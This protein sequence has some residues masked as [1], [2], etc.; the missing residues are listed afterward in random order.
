M[1][2]TVIAPTVVGTHCYCTH[3]YC[4]H[5]YWHLRP[6]PQKKLCSI[7]SQNSICRKA[8]RWAYHCQCGVDSSLVLETYRCFFFPSCG[9]LQSSTLWSHPWLDATVLLIPKL[10]D[11]LRSSSPARYINCT[12]YIFK[13]QITLKITRIYP[14]KE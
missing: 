11:A 8:D 2:P 7:L 4:I 12:L 10:L 3:G 6:V 14:Q 9:L 5:S 13:F 1:A